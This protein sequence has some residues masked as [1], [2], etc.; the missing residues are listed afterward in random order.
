MNKKAPIK[1]KKDNT[2]DPFPMVDGNE[3]FR[4]GIFRI[5]ITKILEHIECG[6]LKPFHHAD[7]KETV[8]INV[9]EWY[10]SHSWHA[11][12][13]ED[14]LPSADIAKPVIQV[15]FNPEMYKLID[16]NHRIELAYRKGVT[17]VES[18]KLSVEQ[19]IP[20]FA[21]VRGYESFVDYWNSKVE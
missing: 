4:N 13:N 14:H 5:N 3:V 19:W 15:E 21:D 2:Y 20:Y 17:K 18:Y 1:L 11:S 9:Q 7:G 16:E 6:I 8:E 10:Q 12:I